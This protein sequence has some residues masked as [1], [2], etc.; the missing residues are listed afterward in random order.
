MNTKGV[1]IDI[2]ETLQFNKFRKAS[3]HPF[4]KKNFSP[5][6][7]QYCYDFKDPSPHF[8]GMFAA[9]EAVMKALSEAKVYLPDVEI[10]HDANG[11]PMV[12]WKHKKM[13]SILVSVTHTKN[14][15]VAVAIRV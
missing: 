6:E 13:R 10:R 7:I 8:A 9:K 4:I 14:V 1:G 15:A 3:N 12:Y 11:K 2:V 5:A